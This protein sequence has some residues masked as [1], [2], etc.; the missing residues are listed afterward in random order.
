MEEEFNNLSEEEKLKAENDF[1]KMKIMLERGAEFHATEGAAALPPDVENLFLLNLIE[2]EK[3]FDSSKTITVF[4][5]IGKPAQFKPSGEI[6][7][8]EIGQAWNE[9]LGYMSNHGI[10]LSASSPNVSDRELYRFAIEELFDH[11]MDDINIPGMVNGFIYDEFHPDYIYDNTRYAVDDCMKLILQKDSAEY[12]PN[13]AKKVIL[14]NHLSLDEENFKAII[15]R[16]KDAFDDIV[17]DTIT[18]ENC[19]IEEDIC[20]VKGNYEA[21][22]FIA[23]ETVH[24]NNNWIILFHF[25]DDYGYWLITSIQI[26]GIAF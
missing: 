10:E 2:F 21:T 23:N 24:W 12:M 7:D 13:L 18:T 5:K 9:L 25:N 17:L 3:Q 6:T 16:F 1:L 11:E 8:M 14:N 22:G 26:V 19:V 20:T 4:D 15:N